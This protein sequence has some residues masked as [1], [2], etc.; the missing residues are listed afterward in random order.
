M[1]ARLS[2]R[3]QVSSCSTWGGS[4]SGVDVG[5]DAVSAPGG[6]A[7]APGKEASPCFLLL[8]RDLVVMLLVS[9]GRV[10]GSTVS[11]LLELCPG[12]EMFSGAA[13]ATGR[14]VSAAGGALGA[15]LPESPV[16]FVWARF[17]PLLLALVWLEQSAAVRYFLQGRATG[18]ANGASGAESSSRAWRAASLSSSNARGS[19]SSVGGSSSSPLLNPTTSHFVSLYL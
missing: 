17:S 6:A 8:W 16:A 4:A 11:L 5:G 3:V 15:A 2:V 12:D 1:S 13:S 10:G 9:A 14:T 18:P 19:S 7:A